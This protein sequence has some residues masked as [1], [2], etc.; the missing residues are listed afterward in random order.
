MVPAEV[1]EGNAILTVSLDPFP[2][3]MTAHNE[4]CMVFSTIL[5]SQDHFFLFLQKD[6]TLSLS[7]KFEA[8]V[9]G[10]KSRS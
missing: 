2:H 8:A 6:A 5:G 10:K 4:L 9:Q 3:P 1:L 7:D